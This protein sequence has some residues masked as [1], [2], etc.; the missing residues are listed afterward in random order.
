MRPREASA[1]FINLQFLGV[2]A[3]GITYYAGSA[4]F[5]FERIESW[6]FIKINKHHEE[7]RMSHDT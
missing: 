7:L 4:E 6:K 1:F 5:C 2:L 3:R